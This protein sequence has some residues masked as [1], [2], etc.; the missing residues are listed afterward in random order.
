V[1]PPSQALTAP[2]ASA[3]AH[4]ENP[5]QLKALHALNELP[6]FSPILN[7]LL[8]SLAGE[9]V[10]FAELGGLIEKDTVIAG[11]LLHLVNSALYARRSTVNSVR[12]AVSV[13]GITKLRNAVL[14]MSVAGMWNKSHMPAAWS[15]KRF[16]MHSAAVA[17]LSDFLAQHAPVNYPEG[18][19]V[20]GLFHD[21]GR[22][23]IAAALP[24]EDAEIW[25]RFETGGA[26]L[27]RASLVECEEEVLGFT[28]AD[29]SAAAL[30][31]WKLPWPVQAAVAGHH[32]PWIPNLRSD[33]KVEIP[34]GHVVDAANQYVNST[35][36]SISMDSRAGAADPEVIGS[37]G[38]PPERL[39]PLLAE[40]R[41]EYLAMMQFFS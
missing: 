33:E 39:A 29:L 18:A 8:A 35:G 15:M 11:N 27:N 30:A 19:F 37:L 31:F 13:L 32:S 7:R 4:P 17:L 22:L 21:L 41:E 3:H 36:D 2:P 5:L 14:G 9:D 6:P 26:T 34:L 12:H 28:H 23:L 40:F 1:A 38:L 25:K 20:A 16:N 24:Q 10:S